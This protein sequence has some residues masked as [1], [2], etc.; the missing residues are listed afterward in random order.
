MASPV[1]GDMHAHPFKQ[2]A[3]TPQQLARPKRCLR[4][5]CAGDRCR[6]SARLARA[7][8]ADVMVQAE[9]MQQID[10]FQVVARVKAAFHLWAARGGHR[11]L[12]P[13]HTVSSISIFS[14]PRSVGYPV[15]FPPLAFRSAVTA[16]IAW[17]EANG[18]LR[19]ELFGTPLAGHS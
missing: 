4:P 12:S 17:A 15:A 18:L 7:I 5:D 9:K 2:G 6:N 8:A 14:P 10:E 3:Y 16:A 11:P 1:G 13:G 19:S